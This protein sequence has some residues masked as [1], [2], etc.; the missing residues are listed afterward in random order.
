[1]I[2]KDFELRIT[3]DLFDCL[4]DVVF[5]TKDEDGRYLTANETLVKRCGLRKKIQL[6]GRRPTQVLGRELG[7]SYESQDRDVIKTGASVFNKL[8]LHAYANGKV[9]WC[10]TNK[11]AIFDIGSRPIGVAGISQDLRTPDT[12]DSNFERLSLAISHVQNNLSEAPGINALSVLT[13]LSAYQ[14]DRRMRRI[15]GL[16]TGQ[17]I[18]KQRLDRACQLLSET[19]DPIANIALDSGYADQ[20]AFTRQFRL[21]TGLTPSKY[22]KSYGQV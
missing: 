7:E 10:M 2:T 6:I 8:E 12:A 13:G 15:F 4:P 5:F 1:M 22:R 9:G 19:R 16:T 18:L 14:L 3:E 21:A 17:W 11:R 20:S